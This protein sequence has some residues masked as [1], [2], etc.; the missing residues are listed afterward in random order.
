MN[1]LHEIIMSTIRPIR[2]TLMFTR[3]FFFNI[4]FIIKHLNEMIK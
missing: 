4:K 3:F 1:I 2:E